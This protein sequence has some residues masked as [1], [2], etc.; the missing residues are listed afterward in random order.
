MTKIYTVVSKISTDSGP[1]Y[2]H[3]A[4]DKAF[5]RLGKCTTHKHKIEADERVSLINF[6]YFPAV[7]AD[8][9]VAGCKVYTIQRRGVLLGETIYMMT[10]DT[11]YTSKK[12]ATRAL[13]ELRDGNDSNLILYSFKVDASARPEMAEY[14][15]VVPVMAHSQEEAVQIAHGLLADRVHILA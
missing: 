12:A 10:K 11:Y 14:N 5:T 7:D 2:L 4:G 13:R 3:T 8:P 6:S 1:L 15:V 9:L